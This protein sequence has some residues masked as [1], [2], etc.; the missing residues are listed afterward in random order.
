MRLIAM[1]EEPGDKAGKPVRW[2]KA[3]RKVEA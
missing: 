3:T 2:N 1:V